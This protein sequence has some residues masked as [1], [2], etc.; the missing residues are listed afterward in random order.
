MEILVFKCKWLNQLT[1]CLQVIFE[2]RADHISGHQPTSV[3]LAGNDPENWLTKPG[4]A[5]LSG[6]IHG[7][8]FLEQ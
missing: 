7:P 1:E 3:E 8:N 4:T 6:V 5:T 2:M